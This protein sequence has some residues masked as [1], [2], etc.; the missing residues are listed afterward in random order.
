[1]GDFDHVGAPLHST[2]TSVVCHLFKLAR[3]QH[4]L[5]A[6][7]LE[8]LGLYPGQQNTLA[9]LAEHGPLTQARLAALVGVDT[10]TVCRT[11]QRLERAGLVSRCAGEA[12]RRTSVVVATPA[13]TAAGDGVAAVYE[14]VE[15]RLLAGL[16]PAE[17]QQFAAL[18]SKI[19][20]GLDRTSCA[21]AAD[22]NAG[23]VPATLRA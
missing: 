1:M 2:E 3:A 14:L 13:G 5:L 19:I 17:R 9:A 7:G 12:D 8:R 22:E 16:D 20:G 23:D 15:E 10:S 21:Q 4:T 18:L 11:L 6:E